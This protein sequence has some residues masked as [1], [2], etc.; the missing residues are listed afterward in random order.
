M[1]SES[2][3]QRL[4]PSNKASGPII[5]ERVFELNGRPR[6][7]RVRIRKPRRDPKT[8]NHWCTFQVSGLAKA[9]GFK[10]WGIDSLQALQLAVRAAGELLREEGHDITWCGDQDLGFPKTYP[11]FLSESAYSRIER[12]IDREIARE[13]R[14]PRKK[15]K[16]P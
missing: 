15:R 9:M 7:V 3:A 8:G 11:S 12:M 6:S 13:E 10:V 14:L 4:E 1:A 5:A 16:A 2:F